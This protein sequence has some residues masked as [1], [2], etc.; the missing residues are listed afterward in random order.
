M[1]HWHPKKQFPFLI[2]VVV[3]FV[4][5][6]VKAFTQQVFIAPKIAI[7]ILSVLPK[8]NDENDYFS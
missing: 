1:F 3:L 8:Q 2:Y 4:E 5:L 6:K 7:S